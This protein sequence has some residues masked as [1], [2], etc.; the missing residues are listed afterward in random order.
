MF[1][2][3]KFNS[4]IVPSVPGKTLKIYNIIDIHLLYPYKKSTTEEAEH[5]EIIGSNSSSTVIS[6]LCVGNTCST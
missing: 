5:G 6:K 3:I 1:I 2:D 4:S